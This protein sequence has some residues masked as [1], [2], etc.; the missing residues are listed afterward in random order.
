MYARLLATLCLLPVSIFFAQA[1]SAVPAGGTLEVYVKGQ[2]AST[3]DVLSALHRELGALMLPA[4]FRVVWRGAADPPST[5]ADRLVMVEL[6]GL[7]AAQFSNTAS[8]PLRSSLPLA[9]S[10]MADGKVLP[11]SWVDCTALNRFLAPVASHQLHADQDILYGRSMARLLAHE[12]YHILAQTDG[13]AP[14]GIAKARFSTADLLAEHFDF[15]T[16]ALDRLHPPVTA[17]NSASSAAISD[18][19]SAGR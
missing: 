5:D 16:V 15:E 7:C 19:A 2:D 18:E 17:A 6:R 13:H 3:P 4:G 1:D 8:K 14:A 11:F 9:S 10:S 12:F